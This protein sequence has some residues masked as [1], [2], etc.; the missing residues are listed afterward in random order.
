MFSILY[1]CSIEHVLYCNYFFCVSCS[2]KSS[3][4]IPESF[5]CVFLQLWSE[6]CRDSRRLGV[7]HVSSDVCRE[8]RRCEDVKKY[9]GIRLPA[10]WFWDARKESNVSKLL[11]HTLCRRQTSYA[12][13]TH[14]HPR[15][16]SSAPLPTPAINLL[17]S[18]VLIGCR[19]QRLKNCR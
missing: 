13:S 9:V 19:G 1:V 11:S 3:Q 12:F 7:C 6:L 14:P 2:F 17:H 16:E 5:S 18:D 4:S 8:N 10:S 15:T